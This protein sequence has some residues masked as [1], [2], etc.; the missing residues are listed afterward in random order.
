M[1]IL[2]SGNKLRKLKMNCCG[3]SNH[4]MKELIDLVKQKPILPNIA[5][6]SWVDDWTC[7]EEGYYWDLSLFN[8]LLKT[9]R[10]TFPH[11]KL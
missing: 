8:K 3:V 11:I 1:Q 5:S 7:S 9:I 2:Q 6:I 10:C 4:V